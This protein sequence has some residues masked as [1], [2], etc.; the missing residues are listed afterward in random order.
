MNEFSIILVL[1]LSCTFNIYSQDLVLKKNETIKLKPKNYSYN[2]MVFNENSTLVLTGTTSIKTSKLIVKNLPRIAYQQGA[3]K[4][5][6]NKK[7]EF[8]VGNGLKLNGTL[9]VIGSGANGK[10]GKKW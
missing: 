2:K 7:F 3:N 1:F 5:N 9:V 4:R 8:L 10:N 6:P